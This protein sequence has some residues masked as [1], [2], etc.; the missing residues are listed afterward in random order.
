MAQLSGFA[1]A[2][3]HGIAYLAEPSVRPEIRA[4]AA[5][6]AAFAP[7]WAEEPEE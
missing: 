1:R 3:G 5:S 6:V 2:A 7:S 4:L